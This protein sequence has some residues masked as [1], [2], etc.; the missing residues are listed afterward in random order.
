MLF[1]LVAI[2]RIDPSELIVD[3]RSRLQAALVEHLFSFA[4]FPVLVKA[5][6]ISPK[7]RVTYLEIPHPSPFHHPTSLDDPDLK[8]KDIG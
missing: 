8:Q 3:D 4:H 6:F 5:S 1:S 2:V 7:H